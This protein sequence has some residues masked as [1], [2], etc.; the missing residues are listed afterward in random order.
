MTRN[1][2]YRIECAFPIYDQAIKDE[3]NDFLDIQL[4]DN[5]KARI[6]DAEHNNAYK[7]MKE[8]GQFRA[9][10]MLYKYYKDKLL[11]KRT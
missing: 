2:Y 6:V 9:Q 10:L 4:K 11:S 5:V 3:I 8:G 7:L 1:L